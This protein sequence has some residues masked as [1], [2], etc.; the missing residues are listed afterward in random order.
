MS[1]TLQTSTVYVSRVSYLFEC[2]AND[3]SAAQVRH[4]VDPAREWG[5]F[6][7]AHKMDTPGARALLKATTM[8]IGV[9]SADTTEAE[10]VA[11]LGRAGEVLAADREGDQLISAMESAPESSAAIAPANYDFA[12]PPAPG[13]TWQRR[14]R[15]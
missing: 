13:R 11:M 10:A 15:P 4:V 3:K 9:L 6:F 5:K 8:G 1:R 14:S 7:A 2:N 12:P